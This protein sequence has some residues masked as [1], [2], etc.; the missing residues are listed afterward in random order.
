MIETAGDRKMEM[1]EAKQTKEMVRLLCVCKES[2]G[3]VG[4]VERE[5]EGG[6]LSWKVC[7]C[8]CALCLTERLMERG[9]QGKKD[10]YTASLCGV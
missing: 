1:E 6:L 9:N 7:A 10:S 4:L 3:W 5:S 2:V 8:A